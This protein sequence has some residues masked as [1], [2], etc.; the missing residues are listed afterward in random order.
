M[1]KKSFTDNNNDNKCAF[2]LYEN[3][4]HMDCVSTEQINDKKRITKFSS[5]IKRK[6]INLPEIFNLNGIFEMMRESCICNKCVITSCGEIKVMEFTSS[7]KFFETV[8][9]VN[10]FKNDEYILDLVEN[11]RE[12]SM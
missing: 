10:I 2:Y 3:S 9:C 11:I 8:F 4:I 5:H 12:L 1:A 7:C 6:E